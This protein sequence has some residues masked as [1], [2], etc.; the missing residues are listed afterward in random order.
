MVQKLLKINLKIEGV[1]DQYRP[2]KIIQSGQF[3][4]SLGKIGQAKKRKKPHEIYH[5]ALFLSSQLPD[6]NRR[7]AHYE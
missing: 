1:V 4:A 3:R 2:I 6:S 5:A 7:P